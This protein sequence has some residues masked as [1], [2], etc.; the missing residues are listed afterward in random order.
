PEV[1]VQ[2]SLQSLELPGRLVVERVRKAGFAAVKIHVETPHEHPHR[3]LSDIRRILDRGRL[4]PGARQIADKMFV[5]L[6]QA[7]AESHGIPI[8]RVH[9]HEVGAVDS[10][11]DFVGIATAID[12]L[13]PTWISSTPV[14]T[15]QG[16]VN[17]EHGK[18]PIP[19]PAVARLLAG[20]PL[21]NC[22]IDAELTTPTGAAVIATL[23]NE[24]TRQPKLVIEKV[25]T[26]AGT[27][28]LVEQPNV[29]RLMLG[30][31]TEKHSP[32]E[33]CDVIWQLE[34]NID[35]VPAEIIGYVTERLFDIG[36]LDVYLTP[37]QMKKN[38]PA[39]LLAVLCEDEARAAIE[40]MIFEETGTLGIRRR[41]MERTKLERQAVQVQTAWGPV[42]GKVAWNDEMKVFTP[43]F[44]DCAR[45]ARQENVPLRTIFEAARRA[46]DFPDEPEM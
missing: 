14:P 40:K 34:T 6:G 21:A 11:F 20:V 25:G 44:E 23:V 13:K 4:T 31:T 45:V 3:H 9:F 17:C 7:E 24:F 1:I 46:F 38:R 22:P 43:E 37:I 35:D 18:L 5:R 10:I 29:L 12:W 27:R 41:Q 36:A 2:E 26:G 15:G 8:E 32:D 19:A 33:S 30:S 39:V 42:A 16:W 28:D